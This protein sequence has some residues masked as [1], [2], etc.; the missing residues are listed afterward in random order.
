MS[1]GNVGK[2]SAQSASRGGL[3]GT[4]S[5]RPDRRIKLAHVVRTTGEPS[6]ALSA[7][8][9]SRCAL[10]MDYCQMP[11]WR[12][13]TIVSC[14]FLLLSGMPCTAGD[15]AHI[16]KP[17]DYPVSRVFDGKA[18]DP[19]LD[20]KEARL[21]RTTIRRG[22]KQGPDFAG[23]YTVVTWG[24]GMDSYQLVV[25][26]AESGKVWF[27]PFGCMTLAGGFGIPLPEEKTFPNPAYLKNSRL[28]VIVGVEDSH[29]AKAKDRSA[30]FYV[31]DDGKFKLVY[32]VP[33]AFQDE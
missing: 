29:A 2:I 5:M 30:R 26:D 21:F 9:S 14:L 25:V 6:G 28:L 12:A 17:E 32:T 20:T 4:E 33:A 24:C 8:Y 1:A 31:F 19:V 7:F 15:W 13:S 16:P 10:F 23:H 22:A 11:L 18:V 3:R 27:P